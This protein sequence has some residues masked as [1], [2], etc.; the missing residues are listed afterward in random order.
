MKQKTSITLKP[1]TLRKLK[2]IAKKSERSVSFIVDKMLE[3]K[4][5]AKPSHNGKALPA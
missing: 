4:F 5:L 1:G 3:E 2:R